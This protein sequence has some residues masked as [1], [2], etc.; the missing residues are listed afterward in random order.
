LVDDPPEVFV[1]AGT[2]L[3]VSAIALCRGEDA[4]AILAASM[5]C[6][7]VPRDHPV[8]VSRETPSN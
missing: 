7:P 4:E 8:T 5:R 2:A 3:T 1:A 6:K